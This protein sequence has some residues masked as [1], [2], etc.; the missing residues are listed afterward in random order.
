MTLAVEPEAE[1][2]NQKSDGKSHPEHL[3]STPMPSGQSTRSER[4]HAPG[5]KERYPRLPRFAQH[6]PVLESNLHQEQRE[7]AQQPDH[8]QLAEG[9]GVRHQL[10]A[11]HLT[12]VVL[13][14][15]ALLA[16]A[17]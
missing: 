13:G 16:A 15:I 10:L 11:R 3:T 8:H 6:R 17:C 9:G 5:V 7:G 12:T 14:V 4:D 2:T 1:E